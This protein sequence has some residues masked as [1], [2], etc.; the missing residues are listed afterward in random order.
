MP[1]PGFTGLPLSPNHLCRCTHISPLPCP[2]SNYHDAQRGLFEQPGDRQVWEGGGGVLWSSEG[3]PHRGG[4]FSPTATSLADR[5]KRRLEMIFFA[6]Q[7][8]R[9]PLSLRAAGGRGMPGRT[10]G[11]MLRLK[12]TEEKQSAHFGFYTSSSVNNVGTD[13]HIQYLILW[14]R[15]PYVYISLRIKT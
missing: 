4:I 6:K 1:I 9:S 3:S 15:D 8:K 12:L 5:T 10:E 7:W 2:F 13:S 14:E 11:R